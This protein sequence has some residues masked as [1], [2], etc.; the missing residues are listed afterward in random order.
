MSSNIKLEYIS[1]LEDAH[2]DDR[3]F[4]NF[5]A[6]GVVETEKENDAAPAYSPKH[7]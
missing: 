5:I 3:P 4:V 6:E 1:L 7:K 2:V